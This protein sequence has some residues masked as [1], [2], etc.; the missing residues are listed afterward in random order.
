M[1]SFICS[2]IFS[3]TQF[4]FR[5]FPLVKTEANDSTSKSAVS[6]GQV[7]VC[8]LAFRKQD[9]VLFDFFL[10]LR[11][12]KTLL[13]FCFTFLASFFF[14]NLLWVS[15]LQIY[16][17]L[18]LQ[19][20]T[21]DWNVT[22][23]CWKYATHC[24]FP[25]VHDGVS[26]LPRGL[27]VLVLVYQS[28]I[29]SVKYFNHRNSSPKA[30]GRKNNPPSFVSVLRRINPRQNIHDSRYSLFSQPNRAKAT[31]TRYEVISKLGSIRSDRS[32][33]NID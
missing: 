8:P 21:W 33:K 25:F 13:G 14:H 22:E 18:Q 26:N 27:C 30:N 31:R 12:A 19:G 24:P 1:N 20:Q 2:A 23:K 10:F 5:A 15:V 9:T 16:I 28:T 29:F 11:Y 4:S 6:L 17:F 32:A 7:V 3:R